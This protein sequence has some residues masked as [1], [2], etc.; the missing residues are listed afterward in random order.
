MRFLRTTLK[1]TKLITELSKKIAY[2]RDCHKQREI[3]E[4]NWI[5]RPQGSGKTEF[6]Q[7][8]L[9]R[10]DLIKKRDFVNTGLRD[11][12]NIIYENVINNEKLEYMMKMLSGDPLIVKIPY[13]HYL[14]LPTIIYFICEFYPKVFCSHYRK[15]EEKDGYSDIFFKLIVLLKV[16]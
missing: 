1:S 14:F 8:C 7:D 16:K 13:E 3:P 11:Y 2:E 4:I 5:Y 9:K 6:A 15:Y 10:Y 12:K